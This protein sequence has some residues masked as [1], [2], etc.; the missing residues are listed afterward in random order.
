MGS[1]SGVSVA[2]HPPALRHAGAGACLSGRTTP[3][4]LARGAD[5]DAVVSAGVVEPA[6]V[7]DDAML[8]CNARPTTSSTGASGDAV[9]RGGT[10]AA[11]RVGRD[12]AFTHELPFVNSCNFSFQSDKGGGDGDG[13][14]SRTVFRVCVLSTGFGETI[15]ATGCHLCSSVMLGVGDAATGEDVAEDVTSGMLLAVD[16]VRTTL[17]KTGFNCCGLT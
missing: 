12:F 8:C 16:D 14:G 10:E 11:V 13:S 3:V 7:R 1:G 5:T 6:T 9:V 15:G 2:S 4:V 17:C